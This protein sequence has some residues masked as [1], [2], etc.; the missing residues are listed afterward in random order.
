MHGGVWLLCVSGCYHKSWSCFVMIFGLK[1][2]KKKDF[3][4]VD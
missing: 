4:G 3:G 1:G 2:G